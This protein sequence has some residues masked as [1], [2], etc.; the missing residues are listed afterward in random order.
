MKKILGLD[1]GTNSI[2]WALIE[3]N[4][5]SK[6]EITLGKGKILGMGSRIIPMSQDVLDK[7]GQGQSHSQTSERTDYRGVR[8]L[9]QR[10][11]LRR[12][13][14]H[15]VLKVIG[16]L[17][18]HYERSID[19]ENKKGQFIDGVEVKL[20]YTEIEP[21]QFDFIFK[22]SFKEMVKVF[23]SNGQVNK[24]PYDWTLYYLRKKALSKKI[25]LQELA[26]IL[27]NFN[28]KRG[29]YQLRGEEKEEHK[30]KIKT[31]EVLQVSELKDSGDKIK[32]TED[33]LYN[34]YFTNGWK[35]D[36][37]ITKTE[38]WNNKI[39]EFIVTETITKS[40]D[41]K[42]T[43]KT[44]DSE[45]D[46]IA[47][48]KKTEQDI[49]Q[50]N[51]YVCEY[52][53]DTLLKNPHQKINGK[54]VKTIERYFYI[55]EL[56]AIL[57]KQKEFH[58]ELK[59]KNLTDSCIIE[60]YPNNYAQQNILKQKDLTHLFVNDIIF[61]QRPLKSKKSL[62]DGCKYES[63]TYKNNEGELVTNPIKVIPK[64]HPLYQEFRLWQFV[65][66]IR[67]YEKKKFIGD[68]LYTDYDVT[69]EYL[70]TIDAKVV[71]FDFFNDKEKI[72]QRQF[73][74]LYKDNFGKKL[75]EDN[76]RW[77]YVEDKE[78]PLNE[79]RAL[80][81]SKFNKH[82]YFDWRTYLTKENEIKLWHLLYSISDKK[83]IEQA[84][85]NENSKL[86]LPLEIR[87]E[88]KKT[89]PFKKE[90]GAYSEKAIKKLLSFMRMGK[91]SENI[92][93]EYKN[94]IDDIFLRLD[95]IKHNKEKV[96]EV[97][98]DDI[99]KGMLKSFCGYEKIYFGLKV[100]QAEYIF[101]GKHAETR[102]INIWKTPEQ[103]ENYIKE[104]KQHSLRNPIV[105]Q[106]ITETLR[107]VKDIWKHYGKG[108]ESFFDEIHVELGRDMKN[109]KN[110]RE[111]MTKNIV[112]NQNTN[113]RIRILL[114]EFKNQNVEGVI[115]ESPN[116]QEKL[117]IFE[118][119]ILSG[120]SEKELESQEQ[121]GVKIAKVV[122]AVEPT[123]REIEKYKL[124]LEQKYRSPYTGQV[125]PLSKLFTTDYEIEHI[126]PQARYFDNS[127]GNKIICE[128]EI[129]RFKD[130]QTAFEMISKSPGRIV[131]LGQ[132]K[133][134][135]LFT[136]EAY[137]DFVS[138]NFISGSKKQKILLSEDIPENFIS[139]QLN[140]TRYITKVVKG[141]L[142]NILREDDE[143]EATS[144]NVISVTGSVTTVLK[145][146]WGLNDKWNKIVEPRFKRMNEITNSN[147][148]GY[149]DKEKGFFRTDVPMELKKNF[150]KK[151]IDHRHHAMDALV[152]ALAT[153]N[154]VNYLSNQH[155]KSDNLRYDLRNKLRRVEENTAN[156]KT[157]KRAKE[158][159]LP[160]RGFPVE[161]KNS[162]E[163][164]IHPNI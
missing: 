162:L 47:I 50:S 13:R 77:N 134:V 59:D 37:Q 4:F 121:D 16:A 42:R 41:V 32:S 58:A 7:F 164:I 136:L 108:K 72:T 132:C 81:I 98:D 93:Q 30:N 61:Y 69:P 40:G 118:D 60:L 38:N 119:D 66:N 82:K 48:K 20:N 54:L 57:E 105:E 2:G 12:E 44:V 147:D 154:H 8:R 114:R 3:R 163:S 85:E 127:L 36:K 90:Y 138:E 51:K 45:K 149:F 79:T 84:R 64:S 21:K 112:N 157:Y 137:Q 26:W 55:E 141:L 155:A 43:Y 24:I 135:A 52:I 143:Q 126:L 140:D 71:L 101:Y 102:D 139:R 123:N 88:F 125:I 35:Y 148:F 161:A 62:I 99:T 116:Q 63:R 113:Q 49:K 56:T 73:L 124:W 109:P 89:K 17:P 23:V 11:L 110:I 129:N 29:Y 22:D 128:A 96:G 130:R 150:N 27:L 91:Y 131:E 80:Y 159:I 158:F 87:Q 142:S 78:Y 46:W 65:E 86:N 103:L 146:D 19:F 68:R 100:H 5:E 67:I 53:F 74:A 18:E 15:R 106:V 97:A 28:Q 33:I 31:F 120:F 104:F 70:P 153:R 76:F 160:W 6:I 152:V 133:K 9:R 92:S 1:L 151:R 25:S 117:R 14:L 10:F 111:R 39:K 144:K 95:T 122:K 156:G 83:E 145:N 107:V 34:V 75:M 94:R 115:P